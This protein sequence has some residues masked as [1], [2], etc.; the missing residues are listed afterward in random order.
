MRITFSLVHVLVYTLCIQLSSG[1]TSLKLEKE[2]RFVDA[3]DLAFGASGKWACRN[4]Y[5]AYI[6]DGYNPTDT[7]YAEDGQLSFSKDGNYLFASDVVFDLKKRKLIEDYYKDYNVID[8]KV[9]QRIYS[10]KDP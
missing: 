4:G 7:F 5:E 3:K 10:Y 2:F 9:R 8:W 1:Q 6:F